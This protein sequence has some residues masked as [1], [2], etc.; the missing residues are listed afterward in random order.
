MITVIV[1]RANNLLPGVEVPEVEIQISPQLD[2]PVDWNAQMWEDAEAIASALEK[3]LPQGTL[4]RL[5]QR[6]M[7]RHVSDLG[8]AMRRPKCSSGT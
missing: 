3:S 1:H 4:D 2:D 8:V 6:L 7:Q 5:A